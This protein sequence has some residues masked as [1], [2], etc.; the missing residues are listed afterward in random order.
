MTDRGA[1]WAVATLASLLAL[2]ASAPVAHGLTVDRVGPVASGYGLSATPDGG[3]ARLL[4]YEYGSAINA[5]GIQLFD[6]HGRIRTVHAPR[7][8]AAL[9]MRP[10]VVSDGSLAFE[11]LLLYDDAG[12]VRDRAPRMLVTIPRRGR[13]WAVRLS[14]STGNAS[15]SPTAIAPDGAAWR[16]RV[17]SGLLS[18][19]APDGSE[20]R[21]HLPPQRCRAEV[22]AGANGAFAFGP[23]GSV[24]FASLCQAWIARVPLV[25]RPRMWR[26]NRRPHC[27]TGYDDFEALRQQHQRLLATPDG[28]VRFENGRI[29][30]RGRLRLDRSGI[31]PDAI[32]P[33]GAEWRVG[34]HEVVRRARDG[35]VT[36]TP[37]PSGADA[38]DGIP[39]QFAGAAI[40]PDSRLWYVSAV[41]A[42]GLSLGWANALMHVG[43]IAADGRTVDEP[44]PAENGADVSAP[45]AAAGAVWLNAPRAA[46]RVA[47]R[48]PRGAR[49]V[50]ARVTRFLAR[51]GATVWIQ[52]RCDAPPGTYCNSLVKLFA[53]WARIAVHR[54]PFAVPAGEARAI[55][56]ELTARAM[57]RLRKQ[58]HLDPYTAVDV[59]GGYLAGRIHVR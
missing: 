13:V 10:T 2:G 35:R 6:T 30:A 23:D 19:T 47:V 12:R 34:A 41:P 9:D 53:S 26:L 45:V 8:V 25:G 42:D 51:R 22:V 50:E 15:W 59:N 28:G 44:L 18:R 4:S 7:G 32:G 55:P 48:P 38:L 49:A 33:D 39:R 57:R 11:G 24:W 37:V 31:L 46:L 40:G 21:I 5:Q 58:G 29:D 52:V 17:C 43:A 1:R 27:E 54:V 20:T 3:V 14:D 36:R 16:A 56:L